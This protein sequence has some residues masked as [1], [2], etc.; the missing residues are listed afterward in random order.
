[1]RACGSPIAR[2]RRADWGAAR[3]SGCAA[4]TPM[5]LLNAPLV[6]QR[7]GHPELY[8]L[9]LLE[10][11]A[12]VHPA[13]LRRA[14]AAR[15]CAR[16]GAGAAGARSGRAA[17]VLRAAAEALL[18]R[19]RADDWPER[20]GAWTAA[21][22][23][24]PPALDVGTAADRAHRAAQGSRTLAVLAP[25][26]MGG[27]RAAPEPAH[28]GAGGG[29]RSPIACG[30]SPARARRNASASA[31]MPTA[32]DA[33]LR[34]AGRARRA[35]YAA[36]RSG[37]RDRQDARLSRPRVALGRTGERRGVGL[38]LHQGAA[39]PARP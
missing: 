5:M 20:E 15:A 13:T 25:A 28:R 39:T 1:M 24:L 18:A 2:A 10:L 17:A 12:F 30:H 19:C 3:R 6:G 7:L 31:P 35:Q 33:R 9:D 34:A 22:I 37:D 21:Q 38:D 16:A 32:A 8:G 26:R 11:F 23:A 14:D 27:G 36:R 4:D 29:A